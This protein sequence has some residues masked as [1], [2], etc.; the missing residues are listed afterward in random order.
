MLNK[1][2]QEG[3]VGM[4]F[5]LIFSIILIIF[6]VFAAI[7]GIKY[8]L[9]WNNCSRIGLAYDDLQ[10]Q[11]DIAYQSSQY[12]KEITLDFPGVEKIC[13]ANLSARLTGDLKIWEEIN[14]YEFD[15]GNTFLYP[16]KKSCNMPFKNIKHLNLSVITQNKNPYCI[17]ASKPLQITFDP[18]SSGRGVVIQ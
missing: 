8:F 1:K 14:V 12:S 5:G 17:D 10:K 13:F 11:V 15:D 4:S 16:T 18:Y 2:A 7:W 3:G 6:F 9:S